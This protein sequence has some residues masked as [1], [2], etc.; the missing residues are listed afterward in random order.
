MTKTSKNTNW[1]NPVLIIED[2][3]PEK[4]SKSIIEELGKQESWQA[5][6]GVNDK[7]EGAD[8]N[9]YNDLRV[10][11]ELWVERHTQYWVRDKL[12]GIMKDAMSQYPV[13]FPEDHYFYETKCIRYQDG[14]Y[15]KQHRDNHL[16]VSIQESL[17]HGAVPGYYRHSKLKI[18]TFVFYLNDDYEGGEIHFPELNLKV[19]PKAGSVIMFPP[20]LLHEAFDVKGTKYIMT[21]SILY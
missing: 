8:L 18:M 6:G 5:S 13:E 20:H 12:V 17:V 9:L 21:N 11:E 7:G 3:I 16:P 1:F 4:L 15:L 2:L 19:K 14:G 10:S